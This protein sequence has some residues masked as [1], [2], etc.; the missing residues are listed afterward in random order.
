MRYVLVIADTRGLE[1]RNSRVEV[2]EKKPTYSFIR[3]GPV[4][5]IQEGVTLQKLERGTEGR[6]QPFDLA[7][8]L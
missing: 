6:D 2:V 8:K 3:L 7:R 4:G 5:N 1:G